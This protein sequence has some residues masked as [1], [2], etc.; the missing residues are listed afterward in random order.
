MKDGRVVEK[1]THESLLRDE[2]FY[3]ELYKS[4]FSNC[5]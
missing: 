4:Q 2:G 3:A 1:G 5:E